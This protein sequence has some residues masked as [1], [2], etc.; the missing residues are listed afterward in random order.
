MGAVACEA[1]RRSV[2]KSVTAS[3]V[4]ENVHLAGALTPTDVTS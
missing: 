1:N 3:C 4:L 2:V